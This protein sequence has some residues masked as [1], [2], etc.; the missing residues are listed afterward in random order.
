MVNRPL[1]G[2]IVSIFV[3]TIFSWEYSLD[4]WEFKKNLTGVLGE[5]PNNSN[6]MK[7]V[8]FIDLQLLYKNYQMTI[9]QS[10]VK[11]DW[12]I[13]S[14]KFTG[15]EILRLNRIAGNI[16]HRTGKQHTIIIIFFQKHL[17][18]IYDTKIIAFRWFESSWKMWSNFHQERTISNDHL[19]ITLLSS[20]FRSAVP[21]LQFSLQIIS[22]RLLCKICTNGKP[23]VCSIQRYTVKLL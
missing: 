13:E 21:L 23:F 3:Y 16:C 7:F 2:K 15:A 11:Y 14:F 5:S 9:R 6:A 12:S 10:F 22:H 1:T 17:K 8:S 19:V 18:F 20:L 4:F